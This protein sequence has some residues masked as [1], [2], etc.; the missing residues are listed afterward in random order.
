MTDFATAELAEV[1]ENEVLSK[2]SEDTNRRG[3]KKLWISRCVRTACS[4]LLCQVWDNLLSSCYKV[5]DGNRL[6][7]SCSNKTT[8][9]FHNNLLRACCH[10][11]VD[12]IRLGT[13]CSKSVVL[14]DLI[15]RFRKH[16]AT[17]K[18]T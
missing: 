3:G 17:S 2:D 16:D 8:E 18:T 14:I 4:K 6:A 1:S 12:D 15:D 9:A 10:Q 13:T 11:L 7:T 5:D